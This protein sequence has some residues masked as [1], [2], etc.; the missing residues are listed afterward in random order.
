ME[1]PFQHVERKNSVLNRVTGPLRRFGENLVEQARLRA[2]YGAAVAATLV[3]TAQAPVPALAAGRSFMGDVGN[4]EEPP[5][6]GEPVS[7]ESPQS[8]I[9]LE[10]T[11]LV[12]VGPKG[13]GRKAGWSLFLVRPDRPDEQILAPSILSL[14]NDACVDCV[15]ELRCRGPKVREE[16]DP[17]PQIF[18]VTKGEGK[19]KKRVI[20]V[21]ET[22]TAKV[23]AMRGKT[24]T[25]GCKGE[26]FEDPESPGGWQVFVP[27]LVTPPVPPEEA[28]GAVEAPVS[29]PPI[30]VIPSPLPVTPSPEPP[31]VFLTRMDRP[32]EMVHG[33][34]LP[35]PKNPQFV[36]VDARCPE[37]TEVHIVET[38]PMLGSELHFDPNRKNYLSAPLAPLERMTVRCGDDGPPRT[39]TVTR[40]TAPESTPTEKAGKLWS[41]EAGATFPTA[42]TDNLFPREPGAFVRAR[43][44]FG[45][46]FGASA[47]VSWN[48]VRQALTHRHEQF[49]P[50]NPGQ[51]LRGNA[52]RVTAGPFATGRVPLSGISHMD[53]HAGIN[54]G[55]N[56]SSVGSARDVAVNR[57]GQLADTPYQRLA[58]PVAE[59]C[60]SVSFGVRQRLS[61][62]LGACTGTSIGRFQTEAADPNGKVLTF[63]EPMGGMRIEF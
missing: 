62:V 23:S 19:Q 37:D 61:G 54:V 17:P 43:R 50:L 14:K 6:A 39:I 4:A 5:H 7:A 44:K 21:E 45:D 32:D 27:T 2:K 51:R 16:L 41:V 58:V 56:I 10:F 53:F 40:A 52:F 9:P 55:A 46:N 60:G 36:R 31:Q 30:E 11:P 18:R 33:D 42:A 24:T 28:V 57:D 29:L 48:S 22:L 15:V 34:E 8:E 59:M 47:G 38:S 35:L 12:P 26:D 49:I 13:G 20:K 1:F 3:T 25:F 63:V